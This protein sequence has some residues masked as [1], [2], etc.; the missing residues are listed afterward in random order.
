MDCVAFCCNRVLCLRSKKLNFA[1]LLVDLK[2]FERPFNRVAIVLLF[3]SNINVEVN[4][5]IMTFNFN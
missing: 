5:L 1:H 4:L 2:N 3:H